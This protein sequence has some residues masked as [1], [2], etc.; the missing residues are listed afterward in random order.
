MTW[1]SN[2]HVDADGYT[3]FDTAIGRCAIAWNGQGIV[4]V[5][6]PERDEQQT[7]RRA[8]RRWPG[9]SMTT[10]PEAV[11]STMAAI[12]ALLRGERVDLTTV[13]IDD[14]GL[15]VFNRGVYDIARSIPA[16]ST[17][18]YGDVANRLGDANAARAVGRAL[19]ANPFPI[20]VPCHRVI[21]A[22][23]KMGGFSA[24][25]GVNTKQRMLAIEGA[26]VTIAPTL[27][28]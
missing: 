4:G 10:A 28:D 16:G 14:S 13:T 2:D 15:P 3:L 24:D 25:G 11:Q 12:V 7:R 6:L 17:L 21:A 5:Q 20:I 18:T 26:P 9:A 1:T 22:H 23:G 27:F 8:L 19:G